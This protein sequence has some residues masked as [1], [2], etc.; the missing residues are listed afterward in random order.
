MRL[1]SG[2]ESEREER[3][4]HARTALANRLTCEPG[5]DTDARWPD[6]TRSASP[7]CNVR[8]RPPPAARARASSAAP[9]ARPAPRTLRAV[10]RAVRSSRSSRIAGTPRVHR[11]SRGEAPPSRETEASS[12]TSAVVVP[13]AWSSGSGSSRPQ[14]GPRDRKSRSARAGRSAVQR[15]STHQR[16]SRKRRPFSAGSISE[17]ERSEVRVTPTRALLKR[18]KDGV[19]ATQSFR[20]RGRRNWPRVGVAGLAPA[21]CHSHMR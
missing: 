1:R 6:R 10:K 19:K 17:R 7:R 4:L 5:S 3:L 9:S 18:C 2:I 15:R 20:C 12:G 21:A 8:S 11:S 16:P 13:S 14:T